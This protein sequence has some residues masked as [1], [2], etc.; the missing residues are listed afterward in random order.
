MANG[1]FDEHGRNLF[2]LL[3][4]NLKS[5][6]EYDNS[7]DKSHAPILAPAYIRSYLSGDPTL[8]D[9]QKQ[10]L[11]EQLIKAEISIKEPLKFDG[12]WRI[13]DSIGKSYD[14]L[15]DHEASFELY[16][17]EEELWKK[18]AKG[19]NKKLYYVNG[20]YWS[21]GFLAKRYHSLA[22]QERTHLKGGRSHRETYWEEHRERVKQILKDRRGGYEEEEPE[23]GGEFLIHKRGRGKKSPLE[24]ILPVV[25]GLFMLFI[26]FL[27]SP[28][29]GYSVF[30][31]DIMIRNENLLGVA[32][33][34][35]AGLVTYFIVR[36]K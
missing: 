33:L 25:L 6:E 10:Y 34:V 19:E 9:E 27:K 30:T 15:G 2:D 20:E 28:V 35:I 29:T 17:H 23:V 8:N 14:Y 11:H 18:N 21:S 13:V 7:E 36:K 4:R 24:K 32:L 5:A 26:L 12:R 1:N 3:K 22:E 31:S 16:S